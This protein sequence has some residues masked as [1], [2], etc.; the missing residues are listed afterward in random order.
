MSTYS[1]VAFLDRDG[2][3]NKEVGPISKLEQLKF[4]MGVQWAVRKLNRLNGLVIVI[5]NQSQ[6]EKYNVPPE[7]IIEINTYIVNFFKKYSAIISKIYFCPEAD[8]N[9]PM[10]KPNPGMFEKAIK[11][12]DIENIPKF[13]IGDKLTDLIAGAKVGA[14]TC[15]VLTGHGKNEL[16]KFSDNEDPRITEIDFV[17]EDLWNAALRIQKEVTVKKH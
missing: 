13:V 6:I 9:S 2:V 12:F 16:K 10:R 4:E 5:S 15:L 17:V 14:K 3:I 7:D 11:D 1:F 8:D